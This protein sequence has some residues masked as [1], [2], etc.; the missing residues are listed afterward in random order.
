M[1]VYIYIY[2]YVCTCIIKHCLLLAR[3]ADSAEV[4]QALLVLDLGD[5]LDVLAW[6]VVLEIRVMINIYI[7]IYIHT[8]THI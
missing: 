2:M 6:E 5:D 7:Y 8:Y 3:G 4:L 1:Y